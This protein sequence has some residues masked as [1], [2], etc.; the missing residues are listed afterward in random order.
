MASLHPIDIF[1]II[2]YLLGCLIVGFISSKKIHNIKDYAVGGKYVPTALLIGTFIAT[3]IGAG[4]SVGAV[5]RV[6]TMGLIF[7]IAELMKP[8]FWLIAAKIFSGRLEYFKAAGCITVSDVMETLY[9]KPARWI[10]NAMAIIMS[11]GILALQI[12]AMGYLFRYFF[13]VSPEACALLAFGVLV[14]Y[15]FFGGIKAIIITDI[16]QA[17]IFYIGIPLACFIAYLD[18]NLPFVEILNQLP[19]SHASIDW[20]E[21]N[22]LLFISLLV[23]SQISLS[24]GPLVQRYL[25]ANNE[26]QLKLVMRRCFLISMPFTLVICCI[27]FIMKLT[28]PDIDPNLTFFHLIN[29]YLP[30]GIKGFLIAGI[31]AAIM[32]TA[33][34]WLNT[35]SIVCAHDIIKKMFPQMSSK[36]ELLAARVSLFIISGFA[37]FMAISNNE[38][39]YASWLV[40][41]FWS[42]V[43]LIPLCAG[44][45][46]FR[47]NSIS[48]IGAFAMAIFS[49]LL[50]RYFI[51]EFYTV[52]MAIGILGSAIGLFGTHYWQ[53]SR[54]VA[55]PSFVE[56]PK[57][58]KASSILALLMRIQNFSINRLLKT[59][60]KL[61]NQHGRH[62]YAAGSVGWLVF[63]ASLFLAG[64][65]HTSISIILYVIAALSC[66]LLCLHEYILSPAQQNRYLPLYFHF[67]LL[68]AFLLSA[69]YA[70]LLSQF[71]QLWVFNYILCAL[72]VYLFAGF[73]VALALSGIGL[74]VAAILYLSFKE[75]YSPYYL[76]NITYFIALVSSIVLV[77][78]HKDFFQKKAMHRVENYAKMV[79]HQ[80]MQPIAQTSIVAE[81]VSGVLDGYN[82]SAQEY[83]PVKK[84]D[85]LE[86]QKVMR[87]FK[88][89]S[90]S[91]EESVRGLLQ[92]MKMNIEQA[93]DIAEHKIHE[94]ILTALLIYTRQEL[95]RI[96]M[97]L[98]N[99]FLFKGSKLLIVE[100]LRNIISNTFKYAGT[101]ATLEIWFEDNVIHLR[102]NGSG[103]D[104][105]KLMHIFDASDMTK[106]ESTGLGLPFCKRVM[107]AFDGKIE[108]KSEFGKYTEFTLTFP[109][110]K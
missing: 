45:L 98:E 16:A 81:H 62:Y 32:S 95:V 80:V 25:M 77:A 36:A 102:D 12:A 48:F 33:D 83:I 53:K 28:A 103:I 19:A 99:S 55:M 26:S 110:V 17:A 89:S 11:I 51:E 90:K 56:K 20:S 43:I 8:F 35:A 18:I 86:V 84:D 61:V 72:A 30:V 100:V 109:K 92:A 41:G 71:H 52:S 104:E 63:F 75:T 108:C 47:T 93:H 2:A 74:M 42:P 44:F 64:L 9:G 69:S 46:R 1:I 91:S 29:V 27:G 39:V 14:T 24:N 73:R 38:T 23:H 34:S 57:M 37:A 49:M 54:G 59:S 65:G 94:C 85:F 50:G 101:D 3:E 76:P 68:A 66:V 13:N 96:Q 21:N 5:E 6:Y 87:D 88:R 67:T 4:S 105:E 7:V 78:K 10:T 60:E 15:S 79:A 70:L 97:T 106:D 107:E 22:I 82:Q 40:L 58:R 31:L